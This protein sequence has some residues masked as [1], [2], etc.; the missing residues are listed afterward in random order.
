MVQFNALIKQ[1]QDKG[2]KSGW[3]Y[4][5]IPAK[6]ASALDAGN[7]KTFRVKGKLDDLSIKG[8]ALLPMGNGD[9]IMAINATMRKGIKKRKG[10]A[11]TVRL[12]LDSEPFKFHK[13]FIR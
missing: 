2:E 11:V 12:A 1:F 10:A 4:I 6:I 5:E 9:F 7:K 13:D 3:T 8:V